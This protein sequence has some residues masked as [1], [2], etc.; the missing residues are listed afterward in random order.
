M[1][2]RTGTRR[3]RGSR[4]RGNIALVGSD[5]SRGKAVKDLLFGTKSAKHPLQLFCFG[6]DYPYALVSVLDRTHLSSAVD[7]HLRAYGL[8]NLRVGVQC[9]V[10][11]P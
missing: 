6:L 8:D 11:C 2:H 1:E 7:Y 9:G 4:D 5:R 3:Y 10:P